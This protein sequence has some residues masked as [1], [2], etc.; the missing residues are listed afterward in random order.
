MHVMQ[1]TNKKRKLLTIFSDGTKS[2]SIDDGDVSKKF[3]MLLYG[4]KSS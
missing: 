3:E 4:V 2:N 1:G